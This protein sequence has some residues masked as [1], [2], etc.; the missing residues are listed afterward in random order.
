VIQLS[1]TFSI[2]RKAIAMIELIFAI[3]IMGIVLMSAPSLISVSSKSTYTALQQ[4]SITAAVSQ[5]NMIM[6]GAWDEMDTNSTIGEPVLRTASS[7]ITLC[8]TGISQ[9]KGVTSTKGRHCTNNSGATGSYNASATLDRETG[10]TAN[11]YDD[12]DDYN[13]YSYDL[14]IY[15]S[16]SYE[17]YEGDY[18]DQNI[19]VLSSVYYG[20]D[21]ITL[22]TS[23][24]FSNPFLNTETTTTNIKLIEVK[25][26]STNIASEL[27]DKEI[28][29]SAFMCNIGA[30]AEFINNEGSL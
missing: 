9:P 26:T 17:T 4:E 15:N 7:F 11:F 1:T 28:R 18:I 10:D 19:T 2:Q 13:G 8:P 29:L 5:I 23:I 30:P 14:E 3:V 25:L 22:G 27:S 20:D 12:I 24:S 16:E 6:T 21:N